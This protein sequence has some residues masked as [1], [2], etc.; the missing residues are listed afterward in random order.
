MSSFRGKSSA[1]QPPAA[2][3]IRDNRELYFH[4]INPDIIMKTPILFSVSFCL[5]ALSLF[6]EMKP[7]RLIEGAA[8]P[9]PA[10]M[11]ASGENG[12]VKVRVTVDETGAVTDATVITASHEAFGAAAVE[13]VKMWKFHPAEE[14]GQPVPQVVDIPLIFKLPLKARMNAMAGRELFVNIDELTDKVCTWKD[15]KKF[16]TPKGKNARVMA[17][18]EELKGSGI[19]EE[20]VVRV[21]LSPDGLPLNPSIEN[22]KNKE[23]ALPAILHVAGM[24]FEKPKVD[25]QPV[26]LDQKIKLICQEPPAE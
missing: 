24:R 25:G 14:D 19:S 26:Y 2:P 7:V 4:Y 9:Y 1:A 21:I 10:E 20:V 16:F 22:L 23:L 3:G 11:I 5:A 18:P 13:T 15:V 12:E 8:P 17:Y 6:A